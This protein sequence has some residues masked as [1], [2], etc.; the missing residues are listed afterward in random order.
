MAITSHL[1]WLGSIHTKG[2]THREMM[3][4]GTRREDGVFKNTATTNTNAGEGGMGVREKH[5]EASLAHT[6]H[7]DRMYKGRP[8]EKG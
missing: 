1:L 6:H 8:H 5:K 2:A 7:P 3:R 4:G